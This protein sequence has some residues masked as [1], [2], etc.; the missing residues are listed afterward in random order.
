MTIAESQPPPTPRRRLFRRAL[1]DIT[2]VASALL[3]LAILL[4]LPVNR[5]YR[6]HLSYGSGFS[7]REHRY[8]MQLMLDAGGLCISAGR[9][10]RLDP[11][12]EPPVGLSFVLRRG[13]EA[14][15]G[16]AR[17]LFGAPTRCLGIGWG[18]TS[19]VAHADNG[20][21]PVVSTSRY[22]L[23]LP[24]WLLLLMTAIPV[25]LWLRPRVQRAIR[26]KRG[27]CQN[28]GY[29]LRGAAG[30]CP[31]CGESLSA[32]AVQSRPIGPALLW[33]AGA[34]TA[35][36]VGC[37]Y[38]AVAFIHEPDPRQA[39]RPARPPGSPVRNAAAYIDLPEPFHL[40]EGQALKL[41]PVDPPDIKRNALSTVYRARII[42]WD[43]GFRAR[44]RASVSGESMPLHFALENVLGLQRHGYQLS[45]ELKS[46]GLTGDWVIRAGASEA[47]KMADLSRI[48][49]S[50]CGRQIEFVQEPIEREVIIATGSFSPPEMDGAQPP[51]RFA[52][53]DIAEDPERG[54]G[55]GDL[56][57]LLMILGWQM[58]VP[59]IDETL[60]TPQSSKRLQWKYFASG[61]LSQLAH[62][63]ERAERRRQILQAIADQTGIAFATELRTDSVWVAREVQTDVTDEQQP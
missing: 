35:V 49:S 15:Q 38:L 21:V 51:I 20:R 54:G 2:V 33:R 36:V 24:Y 27:L 16:L 61:Q 44:G 58:G 31:E 30:R 41:V 45:E 11:S 7:S 22:G 59:V 43:G 46:L 52:V 1:I 17:S 60:P 42:H 55:G 37:L 4:L 47:E 53:G 9:E 3:C 50:A 32:A 39:V 57:A 63:D 62:D 14:V 40:A 23:S 10:Q 12:Y 56:K 48:V 25:A 8:T 19:S 26:G 13:P 34:A 18:T 28:C 29:D 5:V 6:Q